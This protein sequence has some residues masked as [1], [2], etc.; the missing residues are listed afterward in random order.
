MLNV[1]G[2]I[3]RALGVCVAIYNTGSLAYCSHVE[4]SD[5]DLAVVC[6]TGWSLDDLCR[7]L[8][9]VFPGSS[10]KNV[11]KNRVVRMGELCGMEVDLQV[12]P[13]HEIYYIVMGGYRAHMVF[14]IDEY[15]AMLKLREGKNDSEK[16]ELKLAHYEKYM[17][18]SLNS[19]PSTVNKSLDV[20]SKPEVCVEFV[21]LLLNVLGVRGVLTSMKIEDF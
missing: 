13:I 3:W 10:V 2:V 1:I 9:E 21:L 8:L 19:I 12:R 14:N 5:L 16:R 18:F 4:D 15:S 6:P 11:G 20:F 17:D 7:R